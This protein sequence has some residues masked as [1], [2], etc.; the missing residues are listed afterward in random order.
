VSYRL[1][2]KEEAAVCAQKAIAVAETMDADFM[3]GKPTAIEK[4]YQQLPSLAEIAG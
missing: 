4:Y 1:G 3:I 2:K